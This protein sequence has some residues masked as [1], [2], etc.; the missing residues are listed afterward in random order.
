VP[1][2]QFDLSQ[3]NLC[4]EELDLNERRDEWLEK[5]RKKRKKRSLVSFVRRQNI[6]ESYS[7]V[8]K[9]GRNS[10]SVPGACPC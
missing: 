5:S 10:G 2:D 1:S 8:E 4:G 3:G 7:L 9:E 6:R